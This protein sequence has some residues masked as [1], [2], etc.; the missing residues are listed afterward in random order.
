MSTPEDQ[1][2][3]APAVGGPTGFSWQKLASWAGYA[4]AIMFILLMIV[5]MTF[6]PFFVPFIV[7]FGGVGWWASRGSRVSAIVLG[8][9]AIIF[10][11]MNAPFIIPTLAVPASLIDFVSTAWILLAAITA[12]VAGFLAFRSQAPSAAPR[13]FQRVVA[14][15]AVV[16]VVVSVISSVTYDNATEQEGDLA[17]T[18]EDIEFQPESLDAASGT[19]AVFVTNNDPTLHTF[20]IDELDVDLDIPA[21]STARIEFEA[22]AGDYEFYCVP[23]EEDMKGTFEIQ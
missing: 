22:D 11:A 18:A 21:N 6:I 13:T 5:Y 19:V 8:V 7:V 15:L 17:V 20:T 16:A 9:L 14:G 23:H 12:V 3:P 4:I 10:I 2:A 1:G